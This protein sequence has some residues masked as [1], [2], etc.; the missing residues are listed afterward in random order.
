MAV[1][2][3]VLFRTIDRSL[4]NLRGEKVPIIAGHKLLYRCNLE[5]KMCPFWRREDEELLKLPDEIRVMDALAQAGVSFLG[6][7]G[8]EPLLRRDLPE[9]LRA[10]HER[11]HTSLVTN[12]WLLEHRLP[13]FGGYLDLLFVSLDGIGETHDTLRGIPRS[14]DRA[15]AGMKA[16]REVVPTVISHTVT[17]DNLDHAERI[18]AL[19]EQLGVGVT[20]QIAYDY[21]TAD[22]LSP[23]R[24]NLLPTIERL[25][26][27][28][29]EGAPIMESEEYFDAIIGSWYG[30]KP[31]RCKPWLTI[32][33][34]PSGRVVLPCYVLQEYSGSTPVWDV[35]VRKLWNT[36]DWAPYESC[37][38]CALACYLEPSL[39]RWTNMTHVRERVFNGTARYMR[40][41]GRSRG[42]V[43]I[44]RQLPVVG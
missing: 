19:A 16:S 18:V 6:F 41:V 32:N 30:D 21:R 10:S 24:A 23:E 43:P 37:N 36:F 17:R 44:G 5:C 2:E 14:F 9:I 20:V 28:K 39:F 22:P 25:R 4:R 27:L 38:K 29:H 40:R 7:E 3:P 34:D 42:H 12:G 35:D 1:V 31:W 15:V 33:V 11:F 8:G 13:E 26:D